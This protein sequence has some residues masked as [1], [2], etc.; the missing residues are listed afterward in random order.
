MLTRCFGV[1]PFVGKRFWFWYIF[2]ALYGLSNVISFSIVNITEEVKKFDILLS[3]CNFGALAYRVHLVRL[4][5]HKLKLMLNKR[6]G[7][8]TIYP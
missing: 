2:S 1:K 6:L 3:N 4:C 8:L 5:I 7:F